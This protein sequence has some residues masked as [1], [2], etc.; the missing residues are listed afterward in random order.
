M[1]RRIIGWIVAAIV[2]VGG[3]A[4]A[5]VF[6]FAGGSGEPSTELTTP[7][8]IGTTTTAETMT[9][10]TDENTTSTESSATTNAN[11]TGASGFVI[12]PEQSAASFEIDEILR[13]EPK[14]VVGTTDQVA[15]QIVVEADDLG[16]SQFSEI[17]INA[18]TFT[19]DSERR[20][21]AIRGP[22]ILNSGSDEHELIT[23]LPT[24]LGG[25]DGLAATTGETY[26]FTVT[27]DLTIR[28]ATNP[29]TFDATVS[30]LDDT[31]IEG[32]AS[33]QVLRSE[34]GIDIPS[35]A[36]VADVTDEVIVQLDFVARVP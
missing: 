33:T 8:V 29:V 36:F 12:D 34:F 2:A 30:M 32:S 7:E 17:V 1:N 6:Y 15:G 31:T 10:R 11:S 22:V 28:D 13:G 21:R 19:T 18:R 27:G 3:A 25:L 5:Y 23:F 9:T 35:V 24:S 26:E 16:A 20:N 14:N 4:L